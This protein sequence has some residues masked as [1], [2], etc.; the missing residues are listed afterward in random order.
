MSDS[1]EQLLYYNSAALVDVVIDENLDQKLGRLLH[2]SRDVLQ[3]QRDARFRSRDFDNLVTP[4]YLLNRSLYF[5][6]TL[7]EFFNMSV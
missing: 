2:A 6:L 1:V 3:L 7:S 4:L 5:L